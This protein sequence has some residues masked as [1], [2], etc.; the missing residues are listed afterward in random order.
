M[1]LC[2]TDVILDVV[3]LVIPF[4]VM[5]YAMTLRLDDESARQLAE[6]AEGRPSRSA[7]IVEAIHMA[8]RSHREQQLRA[9]A[10]AL[11]NDP[12]DRAEIRAVRA[13][14]DAHGAW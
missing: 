6:L 4:L 14:M 13:E 12:G 1:R 5:V 9:E 10:E 8:Y 11:V 7:A 3:P 2:E